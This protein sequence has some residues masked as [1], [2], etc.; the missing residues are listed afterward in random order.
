[1]SRD[2]RETLKQMLRDGPLHL[3]GDVNEQRPLLDSLLM[4]HPL[5]ADVTTTRTTL[6]GVDAVDITVTDTAGDAVLV[7]FHGGAYAIGSG[8][9]AAGMASD[10]A[11]RSGAKA[12]SVDYRLA[13]E[14]PYPAAVD[15][16]VA[17]YRALLDSGVPAGRIAVGGESAGGGLAVAMLLAARDR[18]LAQPAC[19]VVFSPWVDLTL[20]GASMTGKV[21][22][23][24]ALNA[25]RLARRVTDYAG[26]NA[27]A[28]PLISPIFA[29]LTGLPPLLVQAGSHEV[30]LDDAV[31]LAD[32]AAAADVEVTLQVT[33]GVPHVFQ[34]FPTIL[35]EAVTALDRAGEFL[36]HH[37][38]TK[39]L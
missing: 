22:V 34:G 19:A 39:E 7:F 1:M 6:G 20:S 21:D 13:P 16:A 5:P 4:A 14:N 23:D 35:D 31:R 29:E 36:R 28:D 25:E 3:G 38:G 27:A 12:Y 33:P 11:R 8:A 32:R 30:L 17:F 26:T 10:L 2:Q 15:D 24:P 18:G 9:G 37:L